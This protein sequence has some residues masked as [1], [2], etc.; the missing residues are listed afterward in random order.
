LL[1]KIKQ[2]SKDHFDWF[3]NRLIKNK[4][5][6]GFYG[7][8]FELSIAVSLLEK[9]IEYTKTESPD[10]KVEF[11]KQ[12]LFIECGSAQ[13]DFDSTPDQKGIYTKLKKTLISKMNER[14]SSPDT[15]LFVD[16]T[17]LFYHANEIKEHLTNHDLLEILT[18]ANR[19]V[20]SEQ[21]FGVVVMF[22]FFSSQNSED[23]RTFHWKTYIFMNNNTNPNWRNFFIQTGVESPE[24]DQKR[25]PKF[26]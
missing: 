24:G 12:E 14:Y 16:I 22:C 4:T 19:N 17:N 9:G 8:K 2:N 5:N 13:F 15:A 3:A 21:I 18:S 25:L 6:V 10:F 20:K 23:D 7:D 11:N 1:R 26:H